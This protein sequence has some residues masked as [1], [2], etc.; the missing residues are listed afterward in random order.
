MPRRPGGVRDALDGGEL[1]L[2]LHVVLLGQ[3]F[4]LFDVEHRVA[5]Q[6]MDIALDILTGVVLLGLR[7]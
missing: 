1:R 2:R 6:E 4:D 7:D 3:A 5:F